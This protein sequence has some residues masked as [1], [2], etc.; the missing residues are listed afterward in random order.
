MMRFLKSIADEQIPPAQLP[1]G[2][3]ETTIMDLLWAR[4][5]S[6]VHDVLQ[7]LDRPLAYTTV[8]TTL[9]RLFKKGLL[10][11]RKSSRAFL[12]SPRWSRLEW[13]QKRAGEFVAGFLAGPQPAGELLISCLVDAVGKQD[14]ALLDD[15]EKKIRLKRKELYQRRKA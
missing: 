1:L 14:E 8:M 9:D 10:D 11:R 7:R 5:D 12:Y 4:G 3:L 6:N 13:E 15:L 2:H